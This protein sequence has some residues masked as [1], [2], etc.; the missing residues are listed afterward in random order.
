MTSSLLSQIS[1]VRI[2]KTLSEAV[3][4]RMRSSI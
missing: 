4:C 2:C 1:F 3:Q